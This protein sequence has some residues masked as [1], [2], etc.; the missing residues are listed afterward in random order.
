MV[1]FC[2]SNKALFLNFLNHFST[3]KI[4]VIN[5]IIVLVFKLNNIE[6]IFKNI[7]FKLNLC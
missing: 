6:I 7:F 5:F 3:F 4:I 2:I 1:I